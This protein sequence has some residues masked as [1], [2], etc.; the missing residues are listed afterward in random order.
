MCPAI[1][2]TAGE[3][4]RG[5]METLLCSPASRV[6]IVLGKFLLV[7]TGSLSAMVMSLL[8]M[9]VTAAIAGAFLLGHRL[10]TAKLASGYATFVSPLGLLGVLAVIGPVAVFFS[11]VQLTIALFA[12]STKEAQS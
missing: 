9:G 5:T 10:P 7:L 1:D 2:L 12:R 4:E 8:S 11:A 6:E 3:K